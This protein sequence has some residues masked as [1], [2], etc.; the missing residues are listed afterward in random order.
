MVY[1]GVFLL[2]ILLSFFTQYCIRRKKK[3]LF[4]ILL[5]F[6]TIL[7]LCIL[8]GL[9]DT[10]IG[11]DTEVYL[12]PWFERALRSDYSSYIS[13]VSGERG[14]YT[15]VYFSS[16]LS[17]STF[18]LFFIVEL[19][20]LF[21][22]MISAYIYREQVDFRIYIFVLCLLLYNDTL[23]Y[24]R[25]FIAGA[26]LVLAFVLLTK[27]HY[28]WSFIFFG[29]SPFFHTTAIYL[30]AIIIIVYTLKNKYLL[31]LIV[32]AYFLVVFFSRQVVDNVYKIGII[33]DK[34]YN[35]F[36]QY[37][38]DV[39]A[40]FFD[41][42]IWFVFFMSP[43]IFYKN[44]AF[45]NRSDRTLIVLSLFGIISTFGM[46]LSGYFFRITFYSRIFIP[47]IFGVF[48]NKVHVEEKYINVKIIAYLFL[49]IIFWMYF[50]PYLNYANT[51][52]YVFA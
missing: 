19:S 2:T 41:I 33:D 26:F 38:T 37:S 45:E 39:N 44:G 31:M 28:I 29:L 22:L 7:P 35:S 10:S 46:L 50:Y 43:F 27:K 51:F 11:T 47:I 16:L 40:N 52:P 5:M 32:I 12:I 4:L 9:R 15:L 21:P 42:I 30:I 25:Q 6:I 23:C 18:L 3:N 34:Y 36:L 17:S 24:M 20:I 48:L 49:I 1:I 14:F 13:L 8:A